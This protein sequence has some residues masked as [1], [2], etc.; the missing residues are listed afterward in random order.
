MTSGVGIFEH[1]RGQM[2]DS[3]S[4]YFDNINIHSAIWQ[5]GKVYFVKYTILGSIFCH[6]QE[7][8][9]FDY[10]KWRN[11]NAYNVAESRPMLLPGF[12]I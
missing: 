11:K 10:P 2:M 6:L 12:E 4:N 9:I 3:L 1:V 7:S 5:Q 8:W